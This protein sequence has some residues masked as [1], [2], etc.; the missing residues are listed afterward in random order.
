MYAVVLNGVVATLLYTLPQIEGV[1]NPECLTEEELAKHSIYP[2]AEINPEYNSRLQRRTDHEAELMDGIVH[3]NYIYENIPI[4]DVQAALNA[5]VN[6]QAFNLLQG[7]DWMVLRQL[8]ASIPADPAVL[9]YRQAVRA[10]ANQVKAN[11]AIYTLDQLGTYDWSSGW[12]QAV[13]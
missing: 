9:S 11:I 5:D 6:R 13:S 8:E 3:V 4:A 12:P 2:V 10:Y 1:T 7:S